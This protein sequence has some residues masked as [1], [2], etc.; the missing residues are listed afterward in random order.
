MRRS[1]PD[2]HL[3]H[4]RWRDIRHL[5]TTRSGGLCEARTPAC[6]AGA[7]G[8]LLPAYPYGRPVVSS[9][10][11][12]RA[13][14]MGGTSREDVH[15]LANLLIICGDGVTGCHGWIECDER[16]QARARGLWVPQALDP[17]KV[18][19]ELSSGRVVQLD[20]VGVFYIDHWYA[21]PGQDRPHVLP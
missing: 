10:Q 12:R 4:L 14:G 2:N 17:A 18:C 19:V 20:P 5:L 8:S 9:V 21:R 1:L 7:S 3:S 13:Q 11:H 15:G 16:E 6:L